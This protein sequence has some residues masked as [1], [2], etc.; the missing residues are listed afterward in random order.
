MTPQHCRR[1]RREGEF[2]VVVCD[3]WERRDLYTQEW[4]L[5]PFPHS[6]KIPRKYRMT[7]LHCRRDRREGEFVVVVCDEWERSRGVCTQEWG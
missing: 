6:Y 5:M 7:P 3:E 4:K 1:E 2:V